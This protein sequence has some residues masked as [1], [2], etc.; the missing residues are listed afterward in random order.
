M[1][2]PARKAIRGVGL[3][4]MLISLAVAAALLAATAIALDAAFRGHAINV[5][6][7]SLMQ[8]ARIA[9]HRISASVR[10]TRAH[11]PADAALR[12]QFAEGATVTDSAIAMFDETGVEVVY[13]W[14]R[15][16]SCLMAEIDG[17]PHILARGV[18]A[19]AVRME[20]MRSA[21]SLRTGGAWDL[22]RRAEILLTIRTADSAHV[23][24]ST[25]RQ[26]L[27]LS[28]AAVP[29]QNCW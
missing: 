13:R 23:A 21:A 28:A 2:A 11:A 5:E 1:I 19:F 29:R 16:A 6:Q 26:T 24:E 15:D 9:L 20:P 12:R 8:Q 17:T 18:E 7:S 4:E 27:T 3:I 10:A 22:L 25:G 14:D